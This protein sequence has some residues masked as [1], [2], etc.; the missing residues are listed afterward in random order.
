M[1]ANYYMHMWS[2]HEMKK[3]KNIGHI[4]SETPYP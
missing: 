1:N 2:S 4:V 3:K